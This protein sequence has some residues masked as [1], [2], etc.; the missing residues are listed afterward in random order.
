MNSK[1]IVAA[2][3]GSVAAFLLGWLIWGMLLMD[4]FTENTYQYEGLMINP[5]ILWAI[6]IANLATSL[7]M[8][9]LFQNMNVNSFAAGM[10]WGA[11][12]NFFLG[13]SMVMYY[14]SM[15]NWY[16]GGS[17]MAVDLIVNVVFGA[18]VGGVVGAMLGR[19]NKPAAG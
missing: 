11:T 4:Y 15:M 6:F 1:T 7:L 3:V 5:P 14:Y 12:I 8:A 19:G 9:L 10:R 17:V 13:L 18:V 2:V 16:K